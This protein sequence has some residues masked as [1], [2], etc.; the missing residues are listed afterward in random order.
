MDC[1]GARVIDRECGTADRV[2]RGTID[3]NLHLV[4]SESQVHRNDDTMPGVDRRSR[5]PVVSVI[6][7]V[8]V[9][10]AE[11]EVAVPVAIGVAV[12]DRAPAAVVRVQ[13][14]ENQ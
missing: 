14:V 13:D 10:G 6:A 3:V 4:G 2:V 11:P 7:H 9:T 12:E 1:R 5:A 8:S